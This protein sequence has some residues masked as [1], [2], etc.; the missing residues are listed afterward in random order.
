MVLLIACANVANLLLAR[1]SSR[2][3]EFATRAALGASRGQILRQLLSE[4]LLLSLAGGLGGLGLGVGGVRLLCA[5]ALVIF[6]ALEKT[7]RRLR[8]MF[9]CC[10]LL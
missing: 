9:A 8:S 1:H 10:C 3:R 2:N 7:A 5:L 6:L 4:S